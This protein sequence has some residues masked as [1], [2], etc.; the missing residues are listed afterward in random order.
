MTVEADDGRIYNSDEFDWSDLT[1]WSAYTNWR[2][3]G[4]GLG[5]STT[6]AYTLTRVDLEQAGPSIPHTSTSALGTLVWTWET[7]ANDSAWASATPPF[8]KRYIRPTVTITNA[9]AAPALISASVGFDV[10]PTLSELQVDVDTSTLGGSVGARTLTLQRTFATIT[11][12]QIRA[13]ESETNNIQAWATDLSTPNPVI[14]IVDLDTWGKSDT[15]A[16]VRIEILG[17]AG[18]E[19]LANGD[20]APL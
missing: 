14:K 18:I 19:T 12:I 10:A 4:S 17:F 6:L 7:S 20:I 3:F 8:T 5:I 9:G 16:T 13:G 1:A 11:D 15:D 2:G